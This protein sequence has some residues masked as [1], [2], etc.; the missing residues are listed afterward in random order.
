[1]SGEINLFNSGDANTRTIGTAAAS[2][3]NFA[4]IT[5]NTSIIPAV[6]ASRALGDSVRSWL[7]VFAYEYCDESG[8][9]GTDLS[10][11][12]PAGEA[13]KTLNVSGGIVTGATCGVP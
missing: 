6:D 9:C 13:I 11:S 10:L 3:S 4:G 1:L 12:C 5:V 7:Q 8:T 2:G